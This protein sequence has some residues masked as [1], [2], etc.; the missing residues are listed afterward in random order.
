MSTPDD[1]CDDQLEIVKIEDDQSAGMVLHSPAP[2][3]NFI[4]EVFAPAF[5]VVRL[6]SFDFTADLD[7]PPPKIPIY[8]K[9]CSLVFYDSVI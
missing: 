9:V 6:A 3:F 8:Q 2:E 7:L 4:C 5:D 1:C